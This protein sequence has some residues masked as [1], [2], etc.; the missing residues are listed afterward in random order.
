[1]ANTITLECG[2]DGADRKAIADY[3]HETAS[4]TATVHTPLGELVGSLIDAI[5]GKITAA[6]GAVT[7]KVAR[8]DADERMMVR[9]VLWSAT[10]RARSGLTDTSGPVRDGM[11]RLTGQWGDQIGYDARPAWT[12]PRNKWNEPGSGLPRSIAAGDDGWRLDVPPAPSSPLGPRP[13]CMGRP[14]T[15]FY[16][17]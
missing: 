4:R 17:S 7:V 5:A 9:R 1:M 8:L 13:V 15:R 2:L 16:P 3:L 11:E 12:G 10:D 6:P 14:A